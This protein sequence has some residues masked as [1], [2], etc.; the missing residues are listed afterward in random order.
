MRCCKNVKYL[1]DYLD[2]T[3]APGK[4][5]AISAHQRHCRPCHQFIATLKN[6]VK[7]LKNAPVAH[8]SAK[9]RALLRRKLNT[10]AK[11]LK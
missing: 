6:T 10:L 7:T 2:H 3:L 11:H 8:P 1:S 4:C 5:Q 9:S